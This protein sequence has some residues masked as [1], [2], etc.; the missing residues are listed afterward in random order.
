MEFENIRQMIAEEVNNVMKAFLDRGPNDSLN[1]G[2]FMGK[3]VDNNDPDK[4]GRCK[5]R[6]FNV[7]DDSIQDSDL[8]WALPEFTFVGSL[9]GSFIVPPVDAIVRIKFDN[10]DIYRPIYTTKVVDANN[11]PSDKNTNYPDMMV[12]FET[13][14]GDKFTIDRSNGDTIYTHK[15]GH[16][17]TIKN[18]EFT[19]LTKNGNTL[20]IDE[21]ND[22]ITIESKDTINI[23]S[24]GDM[25]VENTGAVIIDSKSTM[26]IK[27]TGTMTIQS[28]STMDVKSTGVMSVVS[29]GSMTVQGT[30]VTIT[31]PTSINGK[32][33]VA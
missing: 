25:T 15:N 3:V 12:F 23:K 16:T 27:S 6:V 1:D 29:Q 17:I 7:F 33:T 18:D 19:L 5:I 21:S 4:Q 20:K 32:F 10:G 9:V 30:A 24:S 11:L 31:G 14:D 13:D 26:D 28:S 8:P 22:N 2:R